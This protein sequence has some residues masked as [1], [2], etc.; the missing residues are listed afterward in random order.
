[1]R[2]LP[3][4]NMRAKRAPAVRRVARCIACP[5]MRVHA[6]A[7]RA[8]ANT[9]AACARCPSHAARDRVRA[10]TALRSA[11]ECSM[12][13]RASAAQ[14]SNPK[15][16]PSP[17][18]ADAGLGEGPCQPQYGVRSVVQCGSSALLRRL[19]WPW[20]DEGHARW[21]AARVRATHSPESN[22]R[23]RRFSGGSA[24]TSASSAGSS[25]LRLP[26]TG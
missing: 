19:L 21:L 2:A 23:E 16:V 22:D 17:S 18:A 6:H 12:K 7:R 10:R 24:E 15:L 3:C 5:W 14:P 26:T 4:N 8:D 9:C 13:A 1:M 20:P 11:R 25:E